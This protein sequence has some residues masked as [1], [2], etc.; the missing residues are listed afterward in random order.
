MRWTCSKSITS[1]DRKTV[2]IPYLAMKILF[3]PLS[4]CDAFWDPYGSQHG[5]YGPLQCKYTGQPPGGGGGGALKGSVGELCRRS[6]KTLTHF[7]Q[8]LLI[9]LPSLR[10]KTLLSDPDLFCFAYTWHT[11]FSN[12][13]P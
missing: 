3:V 4:K 11:K 10:Q 2:Y 6:L 13:L 9:L 8:K 1:K 5:L 12:F 7:R